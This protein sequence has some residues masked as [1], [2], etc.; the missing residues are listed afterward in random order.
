VSVA[1]DKCRMLTLVRAGGCIGL[2]SF[3][4]ARMRDELTPATDGVRYGWRG[5]R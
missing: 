3:V 1:R 2:M 5:L 4:P